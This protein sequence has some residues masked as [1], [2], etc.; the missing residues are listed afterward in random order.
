MY[1]SQIA[2]LMHDYEL[3]SGQATPSTF[4]KGVA[5]GEAACRVGY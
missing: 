2:I 5:S 4:A 3:P 1:T